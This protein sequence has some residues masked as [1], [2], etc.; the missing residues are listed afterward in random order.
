MK[1][2]SILAALLL[3]VAGLQTAQGLGCCEVA[4][5]APNELGIYD[6]SGNTWEWCQDWYG[7]YE[8]SSQT[9]PTGPASG[10]MRLLRGGGFSTFLRSTRVACRMRREHQDSFDSSGLRI[11]L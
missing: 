11:A 8:S 1:K 6:M 7:L 10:T 4:T 9:N 5:K 3:M 2:S